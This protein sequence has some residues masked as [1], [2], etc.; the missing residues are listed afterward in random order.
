MLLFCDRSSACITA[1]VAVLA[2][3]VGQHVL[4]QQDVRTIVLT[5]DQV[6]GQVDGV[7]FTSLHNFFPIN[8]LGMTGIG[9]VF[10]GPGIGIHN[11]GL[12]ADDGA[13]NLTQIVSEG[14]AVPVTEFGG[15]FSS[16]GEIY[17]TGTGE[18]LFS[19]LGRGGPIEYP[20]FG[21]RGIFEA[22][23]NNIDTVVFVREP[24]A[25][26][27]AGVAYLDLNGPA[28]VNRA[29][30]IAIGADL[31]GAGIDASN[32]EGVYKGDK[33][34]IMQV[35]RAG[36]VA[37]DAGTDIVF[38]SFGYAVI[39][40]LGQ[41]AFKARLTGPGLNNTND[42]SIYREIGGN[43]TLV[44][45]AGQEVPGAS[46]GVVFETV[47][48]PVIND[49][50][51]VAFHA[52]IAG[53]GIDFLNNNAIYRAQPDSTLTE[54][55]RQGDQAPGSVA[56]VVFDSFTSP[57]MNADGQIV[58]QANLSGTGVNSSNEDG[59]YLLDNGTLIE[60]ARAG[61]TAPQNESGAVFLA[62]EN[63]VINANGQ[64]AF[65]AFLDNTTGGLADNFALYATDT[66]GQLIQ[67]IREGQQFDVDDDPVVQDLRTVVDIGI[68][69]DTGNQEGRPSGFNDQG[70]IAFRASFSDGSEGIFVSDLVI[71]P[72]PSSLALLAL[73]TP[74]L[75]RR[76]RA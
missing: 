43:L 23:N 31:F 69:E 62:V 72:E 53:P 68:L 67:I 57:V 4:A 71:I 48:D 58:F 16:F 14:D 51:Q 38:N 56:G 5:G 17:V 45:R 20:S 41:T 24:A 27:V 12:Y 2:L 54:V 44:A 35:A 47:D 11:S 26:A 3:C 6:P 73:C 15:F 18:Y 49:A 34:T 8:D 61:D 76:W 7:Q 21:A 25:G 22:A 64:V 10:D 36:E 1:A 46:P 74:T 19:G 75:L 9:G 59:I 65:L 33:A 42:S 63:P 37:P 66:E 32:D 55:V 60:V 52:Q 29:G 28:A 13:S 40:G 70:Q 30:Q 39:N 50:G